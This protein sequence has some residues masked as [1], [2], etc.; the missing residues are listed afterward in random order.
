[1][2]EMDH[3]RRS[4]TWRRMLCRFSIYACRAVETRDVNCRCP[5]VD[6]EVWVT[7]FLWPWRSG[8]GRRP[9]VVFTFSTPVGSSSFFWGDEGEDS[10][11]KFV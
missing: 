3:R 1:M 6:S 2:L 4:L 11:P 5:S 9:I 7:D 10:E 8:D